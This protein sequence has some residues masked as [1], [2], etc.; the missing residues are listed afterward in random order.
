MAAALEVDS[1]PCRASTAATNFEPIDRD[2]RESTKAGLRRV[3]RGPSFLLA[4]HTLHQDDPVIDFPSWKVFNPTV[5]KLLTKARIVLRHTLSISLMSLWCSN[6]VIAQDDSKVAEPDN[7]MPMEAQLSLN[8]MLER[9]K[10]AYDKGNTREALLLYEQALLP[11]ETALGRESPKLVMLLVTIGSLRSREGDSDRAIPILERSLNMIERNPDL[12]NHDNV[13]IAALTTLSSVYLRNKNLREAA[14]ISERLLSVQEK[15]FGSTHTNLISTL[16][17]TADILFLLKDYSRAVALHQ[18]AFDMEEANLGRRL[19][20]SLTAERSTRSAHEI[21]SDN[22]ITQNRPLENFTIPASA[23]TKSVEE[24]FAKADASYRSGDFV[25]ALELLNQSIVTAEKIFGR[26]STNVANLLDAHGGVYRALGKTKDALTQCTQSLGIREKALGAEHP[27]VAT[28][29]FNLACLYD[30][31]GDY[32]FALMLCLR[33]LQMRET[34]FG[35]E[36]PDVAAGLIKLSE[37]YASQGDYVRAQEVL[38]RAPKSLQNIFMAHPHIAIS[39]LDL[40]ARIGSDLGHYESSLVYYEQLLDI[41]EKFYGPK[42]RFVPICLNNLAFLYQKLGHNTEAVAM[43]QRSLELKENLLGKDNPDLAATLSNLAGLYR[44]QTNFQLA[45]ETYQKALDILEKTVGPVHPMAASVLNQMGLLYADNGDSAKALD[46]L[47]RSLK[48]SEHAFGA[49]HPT[50]AVALNNVA[51]VYDS[52]G[53]YD[54]ALGMYLLS[55]DLTKKCYG[56][57]H[58]TVASVLRNVALLQ[59]DQGKRLEA[60]ATYAEASR[61]QRR[62]LLLRYLRA[63]DNQS[64]TASSRVAYH[65]DI[66]YSLCAN[67]APHDPAM[68][69]QAGAEVSALT[70]SLLEEVRVAEA[71]LD[72]DSDENIRSFRDKQRELKAEAARLLENQPASEKRQAQLRELDDKLWRI[73]ATLWERKTPVGATVLERELTLNDI[74]QAVRPQNALVDLVKYVRFDFTAKTNSRREPRYA[75]YLTFHSPKDST[76]ATAQRVDLGEAAPIDEAVGQFAKSMASGQIAPKRLQPI[77]QRLNDLVYTPLAKHLTN[78]AHL[79]VCP[80]G[81]LSRVPF[82]MLLDEGK[83]LIETKT[84]SYV[85]SGREVFRLARDPPK[86][87]TSAPL[88]IGNPD[89]D[90]DLAGSVPRSRVVPTNGTPFP[91]DL[92]ATQTPALSRAY[93]GGQFKPLKQSETEARSVADLL[94]KDSRLRL[95]AQARE[96]EIKSVAS[97]RVLHLATH[98]FFLTD[99][100]LKRTDAFRDRLMFDTKRIGPRTDDWESPLVRCG[101]AL[102]GANHALQMTNS[103]SEDGLLTG[104]EAAL[105]NLQGTELVILSA[106]DTGTG[107]VKIGEGVMSLR[108]A[109]RIAGAQTVLASHWPVSDAATQ[110]LMT[111]FIA[112]WRSGKPRTQAWREAQLALLRSKDFSNPYFWAAFTL[113]GQWR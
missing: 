55:L 83:Y 62:Y 15:A 53:E 29:L 106:C 86:Q 20:E 89:F 10:A 80:D 77:L 94:G 21:Q 105:L 63:T 60:V 30:E 35:H 11:L 34:I 36:H 90:L 99:Q 112:R 58:P 12:D 37:I 7:K 42:S 47:L 75:A 43:Y 56:T 104:Q 93:R 46:L 102:A 40:V 33:S 70:K 49:E 27:D 96:S 48:I 109:F 25:Q 113:T 97:P 31:R 4:L 82:E 51:L 32:Q 8:Q 74:A 24:Y 110:Q 91:L 103:I 69:A 57:D 50:V 111:E 88:V 19:A 76:K 61:R 13:L 87:S 66:F 64:L 17:S 108:R 84:I 23:L 59:R 98:G 107:E 41:Y 45:A 68:V 73:E 5:A 78:V 100:E 67:A 28:S 14:S 81:E 22:A 16:S 65:S 26:D 54:N 1:K 85:T 18:R 38:N 92:A 101:I 6:T 9:A 95:G 79:I 72:A 44:E 52:R 71:A 3:D 2:L 39:Y